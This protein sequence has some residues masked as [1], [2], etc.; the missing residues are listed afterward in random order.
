MLLVR[1]RFFSDRLVKEHCQEILRRGAEESEE[2][3]QDHQQ[4]PVREAAESAQRSRRLCLDR[5]WRFHG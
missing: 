5:P 2:Y 4:E 1:V 3:V